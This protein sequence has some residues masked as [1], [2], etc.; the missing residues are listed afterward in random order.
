[1]GIIT[2]AHGPELQNFDWCTS[3]LSELMKIG[4]LQSANLKY[5]VTHIIL[6]KYLHIFNWTFTAGVESGNGQMLTSF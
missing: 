5:Y 1:M 4:T 3:K 2:G 6:W